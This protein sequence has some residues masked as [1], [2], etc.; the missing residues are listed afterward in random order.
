MVIHKRH[1]QL[2]KIAAEKGIKFS[3]VEGDD[4]SYLDQLDKMGLIELD[5]EGIFAPTYSGALLIETIES[6]PEFGGLPLEKWDEDFRFIGSEIISMLRTAYLT[7]G[8]TGPVFEKELGIRGFAKDGKLTPIAHNVIELFEKAH[9]R[10]IISRELADYLRKMPPGPGYRKH[11]PAGKHVLL[12]LEGMRLLSFSIP[13]SDIFS[14][15]G[16]GQQLRAAIIHSAPAYE[17]I[18]EERILRAF[19]RGDYRELPE[20]NRLVAMAFVKPDGELLT[21]GRHLIPA[22]LIY[23]EGPITLNPSVDLQ[24]FDIYALKCLEELEKNGERPSEERVADLI[25]KKFKLESINVRKHLYR[26][27]AARLADIC[28]S[29]DEECFR[30][31]D[32]GREACEDQVKRERPIPAHAVKSITLTRMEYTAPE[33]EWFTAGEKA[34]LTGNGYPSKSG[35]L[36][37]R[38]ASNS[39]RIP[40]IDRTAA[41]ALR[42]I[43]L[44]RGIYLEELRALWKESENLDD[45]LSHLD[46]SLIVDLL[47]GEAL[48]LTEVGKL[49][50]RAIQGCPE[51]TQYPITPA[52]ALLVCKLG[53]HLEEGAEFTEA[54]KRTEKELGF[55]SKYVENLVLAARRCRYLSA[56]NLTQNGKYLRQAVKLLTEIREIWEEIMV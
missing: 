23:F 13:K 17:V 46:A 7:Q 29:G 52:L 8:R 14:L 6:A 37:A 20:F 44:T 41:N 33:Y 56:R 42:L 10:L 22:A 25:K 30:L 32:W 55:P 21:A 39:R 26:L 27:V 2:L 12:E 49:I 48:V 47:P 11:L 43:P 35:L 53:D 28:F 16:L 45:I 31:T 9:P 50:K 19:L 15:S 18:I 1:A 4:I 5:E 34:G 36:Y 38:I 40:F 54:L 3:D 51:S 24:L